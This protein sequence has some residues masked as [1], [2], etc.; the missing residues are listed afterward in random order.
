MQNEEVENRIKD[1]SRRLQPAKSGL[2]TSEF[3]KSAQK[4]HKTGCIAQ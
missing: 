3:R 1:G 2:E 4:R